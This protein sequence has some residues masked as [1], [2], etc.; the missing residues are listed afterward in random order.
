M[1]AWSL[2]KML[3]CAGFSAGRFGTVLPCV[4]HLPHLEYS[5]EVQTTFS[6]TMA[7]HVLIIVLILDVLGDSQMTLV[8]YSIVNHQ[9]RSST[10]YL[11]IVLLLS[12]FYI[13]SPKVSSSP[14]KPAKPSTFAIANPPKS[15]PMSQLLSSSPLVRS[16][17]EKVTR[18]CEASG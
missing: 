11:R 2:E 9:Y 5:K 17:S 18:P 14:F 10:Y 7:Y 3:S 1:K 12:L 13:Y 15:S 16:S 6:S 4:G 8:S